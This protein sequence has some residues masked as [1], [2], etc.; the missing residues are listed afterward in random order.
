MAAEVF[1]VLVCL[2]LNGVLACIEMAF[3][4]V[5]KPHV[6]QLAAK[7]DLAAQ[8]LLALKA[9]PER[10]LAVLQIGITVLGV[11]AASVSGVGAVESFSG[12]ISDKLNVSSHTADVVAL[13]A[14]VAPLSFLSIVIG[15]LVPK[16]IALRAPLRFS[17]MGALLLLVLDR[18][19]AP[20]VALFETTTRTLARLLLGSVKTEVLVEATP[21]G[22]SIV[23][24]DPMSET[25][26]QYVLNLLNVDRRTVRE[27][28]IPWND[29][30]RVDISDHF[31]VV[32]DKVRASRHTR[33]PVTRDDRVEGILHTKEFAAEADISKIDWTA[34]IRPTVTL[35][36]NEP[37]LQ[38]LRTL[39]SRKS[40]M[41]FVIANEM[42][43]GV[44][45]ME[46]IFEE[47]VGD[48]YDEDDEPRTLLSANSRIRNQ[49]PTR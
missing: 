36:G 6:R 47:V 3:I 23:D 28:M 1:V 25:S 27:I 29:V 4:S 40:H 24:L 33:L 26:K 10:A 5:S 43:L 16:T 38:A 21:D 32:L 42:P 46:D 31:F 15:E 14:I 39:Q 9:R 8:R 12:I 37:I 11:V 13:V 22:K 35:T 34:L 17:L 44:V 20:V 45:T 7:G 2:I 18:L 30:D 19:L 41:G 49:P 48:I